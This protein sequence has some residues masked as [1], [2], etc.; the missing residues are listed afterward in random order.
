MG[1][2]TDRVGGRM[3]FILDEH[4][5]VTVFVI[6]CAYGIMQKHECIGRATRNFNWC[7]GTLG[8]NFGFEFRLKMKIFGH[9]RFISHRIEFNQSIVIPLM[10]VR[11]FVHLFF[12]NLLMHHE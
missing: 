7:T 9:F 10:D 12:I 8:I 2:Y 6:E 4:D 11:H 5:D 1:R 3:K